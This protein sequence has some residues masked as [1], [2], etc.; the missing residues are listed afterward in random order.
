MTRTARAS[1]AASF[2]AALAP[3]FA[4]STE[5]DALVSHLRARVR[6][7][8]TMARLL[9]A[10]PQDA[11]IRERMALVLANSESGGDEEA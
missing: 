5:V 7:L 1:L 6:R 11:G 8:E 10:G 3:R 4:A 2:G 9:L